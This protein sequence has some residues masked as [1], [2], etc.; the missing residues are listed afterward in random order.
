MSHNN[1]ISLNGVIRPKLFK[2]PFASCS[3][4]NLIFCYHIDHILMIKMVSHVKSLKL[5][6]QHFLYF[7]YTLNNMLTC[8]IIY[9]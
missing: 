7:F 6:N 4:M 2:N 3:S 8:F 1:G 5:L 9:I